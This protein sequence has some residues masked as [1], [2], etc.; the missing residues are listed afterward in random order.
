VTRSRYEYPF[1]PDKRN[2]TASTIFRMVRDGGVRVLDL[3]SGPG[4]VA[5][6]LTALADK[7][8]TCVDSEA[9]HLEA[10]A[11]RGVA[12]TVQ[13]DLT[14]TDWTEPLAGERFDVIVLA[15]VLEHLVDPGA[16]L[17]RIQDADLLAPEGRLVISIP[18]ASHLAMLALLSIGEFPYRPTGLLDATHLRFFTLTSIRQ[19]L[20]AHGFAVT[21]VERTE[22]TLA[23]TEFADLLQTV[24]AA[25]LAR[26]VDHPEARTY[27]FVLRAERLGGPG[28]L[29]KLRQQVDDQAAALERGAAAAEATAELRGR[30][31]ATRADA[32][33]ARVE[34]DAAVAERKQLDRRLG[35]VYA[36][37]TWRVGRTFTA[38]PGRVKRFGRRS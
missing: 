16:L 22:K 30:L 17:H 12:R 23:Q 26:L 9:D 27:Q 15:D 19:L 28:E 3:G 31:D 37:T 24:D 29:R 34:R 25:A 33:R 21:H 36:S 32:A 5:G 6:A 35:E 38:L 18:N 7:Q 14:A 11:A 4:I 20:E 8:V 2:N 1:D 10:A 13:G